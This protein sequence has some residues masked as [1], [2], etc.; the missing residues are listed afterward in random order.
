MK[1]QFLKIAGVQTEAA[2]YKKYPTEGAFFAAHPEARKM[3]MGGTPEA[4]PQIATF[5]K[6]FSYG[7]PPGPQYLSHG[8]S[9]YPQAQTEQQFFIPI[10]ADVYNPYNKAM[11]GSNV[12]MY[13]NA[14]MMPH[15]GPTNVWFQDG[16]QEGMTQEQPEL[17]RLG[18]QNRTGAFANMLKATAAKSNARTAMNQIGMAK[19]GKELSIYA[20]GGYTVNPNQRIASNVNQ[21][22]SPSSSRFM[23]DAMPPTYD[24]QLQANLAASMM[25]QA[26]GYNPTAMGNMNNF[27]PSVYNW[28]DPSQFMY[29]VKGSPNWKFKTDIPGMGKRR[30]V[31]NIGL[32]EAWG[33]YSGD[34]AA[35]EEALKKLN[36]SRITE[37]PVGLFK[38]RM[39]RDYYWDP[40]TQSS[41]TFKDWGTGTA[42]Q[43]STSVAP[44][45]QATSNTQTQ[46]VIKPS[47][48]ANN[49]GYMSPESYGVI[50]QFE[51]TIGTY[52][53]ITGKPISMEAGD[54]YAQ[55]ADKEKIESYINSTIGKDAWDKLPENVK[56][57]AYSFMFNHGVTKPVKDANNNIIG[58]ETNYNALKGLAQA[59]DNATGGGDLGDER[60]AYTPEQAINKIKSAN[61]SN[62]DLY[63]NYVN[64]LGDQYGS[65]ASSNAEFQSGPGAN[66]VPTLQRRAISIDE[67]MNSRGM[68]SKV[69][70]TTTRQAPSNANSMDAATAQKKASM[71]NPNVNQAFIDSQQS[72]PPY[73]TPVGPVVGPEGFA[74]GGYTGYKFGGS[75]NQGD[76]VYMTDDEIAEFVRNGGQIE[77][78]E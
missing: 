23:G 32:G 54:Q 65:I 78:M 46:A 49:S 50:N 3:A 68:N 21:Q 26:Y 42:G 1:K 47:P 16:G 34:P 41:G 19:Y 62:P 9:A 55:T 71:M 69:A 25:Q 7:V 36:P 30:G 22:M 57:Q 77:E 11:G 59:I 73:R 15:W 10:Y 44:S 2:F 45:A 56:T 29:Q 74:Y 61:L 12:E 70:S 38:R 24:Q 20:P 35:R 27:L 37:T 60:R 76:V 51:N 8:G 39:R 18:V 14:K 17:D 63:N 33:L 40:A 53:P 64:V 13:P 43:Q 52:D 67:I 6:A 5:D 28:N 58:E 31:S 66:Y 48:A 75:Y 4:F 72:G